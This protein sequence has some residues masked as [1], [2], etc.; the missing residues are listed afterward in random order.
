MLTGLDPLTWSIFLTL[1]SSL[2]FKRIVDI[3]GTV[4]VPDCQDLPGAFMGATHRFDGP[5]EWLLVIGVSGAALLI[6]QAFHALLSRTAHR[7]FW[8]LWLVNLAAAALLIWSFL[9]S[10]A[11]FNPTARTAAPIFQFTQTFAPRLLYMEPPPLA[12]PPPSDIQDWIWHEELGAWINEPIGLM[13][14]KEVVRTCEPV[15]LRRAQL[16]L[17]YGEHNTSGRVID[18][19][20]AEQMRSPVE[21]DVLYDLDGNYLVTVGSPYHK[22]S[23]ITRTRDAGYNSNEAA[24]TPAEAERRYYDYWWSYRVSDPLGRTTFPRIQKD[25]IDQIVAESWGDDRPS[26]RDD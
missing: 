18:D 2:L 26:W 25:D 12:L 10:W 15:E 3:W 24:M 19:I 8:L 4:T 11:Y 5:M 20:A 23:A 13:W 17:I 1:I 7:T 6:V 21:G 9:L 14:R 16:K 22:N